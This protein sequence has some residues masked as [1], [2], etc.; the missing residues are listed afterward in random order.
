MKHLLKV[1]DFTSDSII[2]ILDL[3]K[4]FKDQRKKGRRYH[5]I[6]EGKHVLLYFEK[7]STRTRISLEVAIREL[8]GNPIVARRDELQLSRGETLHDTAEV[9]GRYIDGIAA[10]VYFHKTLEELA[11]HSSISVIN[12]LSDL[13]HPLQA[14][15]DAFTIR[16]YFGRLK[17]IKIVFVGDGGSNVAHSLLLISAM[18]GMDITIACPEKYAPK[19]F[20]IEEAN[21]LGEKSGSEIHV[22]EDP[23]KAVKN[24]DVIY[25]DVFVSMGFER[26]REE[27]LKVFIPRYQVTR[28]LLKKAG[29]R[30]V[31]MHCLPAHRGEEV[32]AEVID[33]PAIS[34]V[35]EQAENR[36]HTAKA[37]LACLLGDWN[38]I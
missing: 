27:R 6:L 13:F 9:L 10:R 11:K 23:S 12:A 14:I 21:A 15:A 18:L 33:D 8:G 4:R 20:V 28:T 24:A 36:L 34:L 17:G 35:Y 5:N 3:S 29:K 19:T 30:V 2:K 31:F 22:M 26:E 7:P 32:L 16:E 37:V 38:G 1:T 25:T